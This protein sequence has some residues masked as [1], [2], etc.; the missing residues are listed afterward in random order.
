M[1]E[2]ALNV[3][4]FMNRVQ[5]DKELF[6]EL[7]DIFVSDFQVKRQ[8]LEGAIGKGDSET[9]EH[10]AHFLK[11]SCG[12]ISAESLRVIFS[13]LEEKGKKNNLEG[14][15]ERLNDIDQRFEELVEYVGEL[16]KR[17]R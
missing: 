1:N 2:E 8:A 9:V 13:E 12:N 10:V 17:L 3:E 14:V 7:L 15:E 11:G 5:N 16:R 4:E 6:F